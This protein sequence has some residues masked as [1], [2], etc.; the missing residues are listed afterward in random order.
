M[1]PTT[2]ISHISI[3][4]CNLLAD[5]TILFLLHQ[6]RLR[7]NLANGPHRSGQRKMS[8]R[9]SITLMTLKLLFDVAESLLVVVS[10]RI[11]STMIEKASKTITD[12]LSLVPISFDVAI[13]ICF[14]LSMTCI[15][16]LEVRPCPNYTFHRF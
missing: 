6:R 16:V 10:I 2:L 1:L 4:A 3:Q 7:Q 12:K 9:G 15:V 5:F 11:R 14:R 8:Q 13:N